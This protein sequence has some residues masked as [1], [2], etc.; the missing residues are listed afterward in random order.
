M[1]G[2]SFVDIYAT[3]GIEYLIVIAFLAA[4]VFFQRYYA[5][6]V[7]SGEKRGL[8]SDVVEWFRVPD[9]FQFHQGHAWARAER[10]DRVLVG[11]DDFA[12]KFVGK[13]DAV[14]LPP[15]G[16]K[17]S[18]G[19]PAWILKSGGKSV[20]ML[21]P[22]DGEV[23][24][25]NREALR[26]PGILN[27][28]PYKKGWLMEIRAPKLA[29]NSRNL[30]SGDTARTWT[31]GSLAQLRTRMGEAMGALYQDG[32]TLGTVYQDGGTPISGIG[33]ALYGEGWD[34]AARDFFLTKGD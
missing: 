34:A 15:V 26:T 28:D 31:E 5:V 1:E 4:A 10:G 33:P 12:Q 3:K 27:Q 7:E 23:L 20:P 30:L 25:L 24:S 21:S 29:A 19:A 6:P 17:L 13:V 32:G 14:E 22:V 2:F 18:Q 9:G 16:T 11:M 8:L